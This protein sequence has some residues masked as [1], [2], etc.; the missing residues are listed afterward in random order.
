[1]SNK[2]IMNIKKEVKTISARVKD[3]RGYTDMLFDMEIFIDFVDVDTNCTI[4]YQLVHKFD[5]DVR[6]SSKRNP[7]IPFSEITKEQIDSLVNTLIEEERFAGKLTLDEWA[8]QKFNE[9][10]SEP[11]HKPFQ[12]QIGTVT[13]S[14]GIGTSPIS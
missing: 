1:M 6:Y 11:V 4:G 13:E 2:K 12:F 5:T 14:V 7:F 10:Y 3:H 8:E 9:I